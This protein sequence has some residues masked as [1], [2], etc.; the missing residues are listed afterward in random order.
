MPDRVEGIDGTFNAVA[1]GLDTPREVILE[2][3]QDGIWAPIWAV[4]LGTDAPGS[5]ARWS[6]AV[7]AYPAAYAYGTQ[8]FRFVLA[9]TVSCAATSSAAFTQV[10]RRAQYAFDPAL[11]EA[12]GANAI[13]AATSATVTLTGLAEAEVLEGRVRTSSFVVQRSVDAGPWTVRRDIVV[14]E[15]ADTRR[16]GRVTLTATIPALTSKNAHKIDYRFAAEDNATVLAGAS[17]ALRV[18]YF[19]PRRE[20]TQAYTSRCPSSKIVYTDN[21][22]PSLSPNAVAFYTWGR[23]NIVGVK[24]SWL[25]T[26]ALERIR[27]VAYHECGHRLQHVT[28]R[29]LGEAEAAAAKAFGSHPQ[30]I[31][32][33]ADC[34]AAA[35]LPANETLGYGGTCTAKELKYAAKTLKKRKL[36]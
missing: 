15:Q 27:F 2:V 28:Y 5:A 8:T 36:F 18:E 35:R 12:S 3:A 21:F 9:A 29:N 1:I 26:A 4:S 6:S 31:E 22:S 16:P 20:F 30:P 32:H 7:L 25:Q 11:D 23:T 33:W 10:F 19:N 17:P 24:Q 13:T 14:G 34:I